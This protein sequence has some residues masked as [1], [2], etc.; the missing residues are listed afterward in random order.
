MKTATDPKLPETRH[1]PSA[2]AETQFH[3]RVLPTEVEG[4]NY[5]EID[6]RRAF[7]TTQELHSWLS[8]CVTKLAIELSKS[9]V[10]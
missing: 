9:S 10:Q 1:E 5:L 4:V 7:S 6:V 2:D 8:A 3:V